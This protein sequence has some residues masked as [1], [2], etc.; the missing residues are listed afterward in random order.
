MNL[1]PLS[2][3]RPIELAKLRQ[4]VTV[5][6]VNKLIELPPCRESP[7]IAQ[8][9]A[10]LAES[11]AGILTARLGLTRKSNSW[12]AESGSGFPR[13]KRPGRRSS[14][15]LKLWNGLRFVRQG[16]NSLSDVSRLRKPRYMVTD[17]E[18]VASIRRACADILRLGEEEAAAADDLALAEQI[19]SRIG[20]SATALGRCPGSI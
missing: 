20:L 16:P 19:R 1:A 15:S 10:G 14:L 3:A 12:R 9:R 4:A 5:L 6:S 17:R 7:L 13:P 18:L 2:R 8:G 11:Q